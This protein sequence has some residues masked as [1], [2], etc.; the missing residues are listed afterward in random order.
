MAYCPR[1]KTSN[2][3]VISATIVPPPP[4]GTFSEEQRSKQPSLFSVVRALV[5]LF[6][7][8]GDEALNNSNN[9]DGG[10]LGLYGAFGYDLTFQF[11]PIELK[12]KRDPKSTRFSAIF[13][14]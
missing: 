1:S 5:H 3:N 2:E 4:A 11:E 12:Q 7:P 14:R 10:Q 13:T 6:A 9:V 8:F